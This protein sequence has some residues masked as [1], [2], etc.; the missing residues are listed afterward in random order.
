MLN[1]YF[2]CSLRIQRISFPLIIFYVAYGTFFPIR[3]IGLNAL[4]VIT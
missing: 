2:T 1:S 4:F 3:K